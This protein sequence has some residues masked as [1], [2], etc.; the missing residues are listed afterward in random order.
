MSVLSDLLP[1]S[2][3]CP[4]FGITAKKILLLKKQRWQIERLSG[5]TSTLSSFIDSVNFVL[6][7][8][9]WWAAAVAVATEMKNRRSV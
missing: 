8:I 9:L 3:A 4:C 1:A 5:L 7:R 2:S 6:V